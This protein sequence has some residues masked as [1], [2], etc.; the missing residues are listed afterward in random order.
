MVVMIGNTHTIAI[1]M[2]VTIT[3]GAGRSDVGIGIRPSRTT[4]GTSTVPIHLANFLL[5]NGMTI[6]TCRVLTRGCI[7]YNEAFE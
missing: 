5:D 7:L 2:I 6:I 1:R 3:I 4:T